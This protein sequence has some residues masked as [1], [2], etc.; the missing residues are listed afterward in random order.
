MTQFQNTILVTG[1][2]TGLGYQCALELAKQR[3]NDLVIIASRSSADDAAGKIN[4]HLQ[5]TNVQYL[6]LDL[7]SAT[8]IRKFCTNYSTKGYPLISALVLN[9]ALQF[10]GGVEYTDDGIEK[11]FAITHVGHALLFYLLQPQLTS[12]A[13]IVTTSSAT[14][15]PAQKTSMPDAEYLT[16]EELAHPN[17]ESERKNSGRQRYTTSKLCNVLW[18]Y[19]L[20]R[21]AKQASKRWTAT[22][23]DPGLMPGTGLARGASGIERFLW[24][25]VLPR[26]MPVLRLL[27]SSNVHTTHESGRALARLAIG[28]DVAGVSGKYFQGMMEIKSSKD[29]YNEAK[30]EDIWSWTAKAVAKDEAE[31]KAFATLN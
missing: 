13:R 18:T 16:A 22:V 1:G 20:D 25:N 24:H 6:P 14:H 3:P 10:P 15:D 9:A 23:M 28:K 21:H 19:A 11:T 29:S 31:A 5:Q 4:H 7:S 2:T 8:A 17:T 27:M 12:D 30:Q 26:I